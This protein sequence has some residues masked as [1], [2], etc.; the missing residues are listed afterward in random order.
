MGCREIRGVGICIL[1]E[2]CV[3]GKWGVG[4][5]VYVMGFVIFKLDQE[6]GWKG[7]MHMKVAF[8]DP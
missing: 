6:C 1:V 8:C 7:G 5:G 2:E 4:I 3:G